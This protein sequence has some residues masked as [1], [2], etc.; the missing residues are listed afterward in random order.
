MFLQLKKFDQR[1]GLQKK[2][3]VNLQVHRKYDEV[4]INIKD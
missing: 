4:F 2:G 3:K 1:S